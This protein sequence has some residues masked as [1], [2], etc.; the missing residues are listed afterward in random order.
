MS[1]APTSTGL[2]PRPILKYGIQSMPVV[3]PVATYSV[4]VPVL[5]M[6]F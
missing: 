1:T 3:S 5:N 2:M 4:F 6:I